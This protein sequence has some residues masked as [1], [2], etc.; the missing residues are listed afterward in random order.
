MA[1]PAILH[2]WHEHYGKRHGARVGQERFPTSTAAPT[3]RGSTSAAHTELDLLPSVSKQP[4]KQDGA[5][6]KPPLLPARRSGVQHSHPLRRGPGSTLMARLEPGSTA[7]QEPPP[8]LRALFSSRKYSLAIMHVVP[9]P[10]GS[11][12]CK[13]G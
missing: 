10:P 1:T 6:H 9:S 3:S 8:A 12:S 7:H 2:Q 5:Q 13:G 4:T 11:S